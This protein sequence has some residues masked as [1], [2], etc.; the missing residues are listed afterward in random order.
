MD[1]WLWAAQ[2]DGDFARCADRRDRAPIVVHITPF[3]GQI[4]AMKTATADA[5]GAYQPACSPGSAKESQRSRNQPPLPR[6]DAGAGLPDSAPTD[7]E[8]LENG[9]D[10]RRHRGQQDEHN[11][12]VPAYGLWCARQGSPGTKGMPSQRFRPA[13]LKSLTA[14]AI[15]SP[16]LAPWCRSPSTAWMAAAKGTAAEPGPGCRFQDAAGR[17]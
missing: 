13:V 9:F 6:D 10:E 15:G 11:N 7:G 1:A 5:A 2:H 14:R 17:G 4:L 8:N 16:H 3:R 12:S